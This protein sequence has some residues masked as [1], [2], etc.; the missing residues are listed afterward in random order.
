ML[1][2]KSRFVVVKG[3]KFFFAE[4]AYVSGSGVADSERVVP[5]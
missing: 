4:K 1:V 3:R 2:V 5:D